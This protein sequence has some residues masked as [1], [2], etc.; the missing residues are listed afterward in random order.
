MV[1]LVVLS[2]S[3]PELTLESIRNTLDKLFPGEFLPPRENANYVVDGPVHGSQFMIQVE[4][5]TCGG[6][7][8]LYNV[9]G[10]YS[11]FSDFLSHLREGPL[12]KLAAA[13]SCW[14]S[15]DLIHQGEKSEK[16]AYQFIGALLAALAPVDTAVLLHPAKMIAMEFTNA[17]RQQL[18]ANE[19]PLDSV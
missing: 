19:Q 8:M 3:S 13:Q 10:P 11:G 9:P 4:L 1:S 18:A 7:F 12:R 14:M 5:P 15:V 17:I 16:S 6:I 2:R